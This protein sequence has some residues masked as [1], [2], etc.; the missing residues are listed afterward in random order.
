MSFADIWRI[1]DDLLDQSRMHH[2]RR[3]SAVE[4]RHPACLLCCPRSL[5]FRQPHSAKSGRLPAGS[6][7]GSAAAAAGAFPSTSLLSSAAVASSSSASSTSGTASVSASTLVAPPTVAGFVDLSFPHYHPR[8]LHHHHQQQQQNITSG[9]STTHRPGG[10]AASAYST[11]GSDTPPNVAPLPP[12]SS[13]SGGGGGAASTLLMNGHAS[14]VDPSPPGSVS[15]A[16]SGSSGSRGG[17]GGGCFR[18]PHVVGYYETDS[19]KP[20]PKDSKLKSNVGID[21]LKAA[22]VRLSAFGSAGGGAGETMT[23]VEVPASWIAFVRH[24]AAIREQ[25]P[26]VPFI[27]YDEV[28]LACRVCCNP[29]KSVDQYEPQ[30]LCLFVCARVC[31]CVWHKMKCTR[32]LKF[33]IVNSRKDTCN[34]KIMR[35]FIA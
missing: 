9:S 10:G 16:A 24:V 25:A 30:S 20:F 8:L 32:K 35:K 27:G 17:V 28:C 12:T 26:N 18:F 3:F 33:T 23:T 22:I 5:A 19:R 31:V 11:S 29:V 34:A 7:A 1:L 6:A 13:S 2:G 15:G 4:S 21:Q 14:V